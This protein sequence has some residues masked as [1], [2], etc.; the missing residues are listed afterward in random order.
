[1]EAIRGLD[2][3]WLGAFIGDLLIGGL[4]YVDHLGFR[5]IDRLF[6][7][8]QYARR[9]IGRALVLS[10]LDR[11]EVR[12]STGTRNDPACRLYQSLD[13]EAIG[14]REIAPEVTVTQF[15]RR[16]AAGRGPS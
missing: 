2:L 5:D 12:V 13:F 7:D 6:V 1:M 9:G 11:E 16:S 4:G 8:P 14:V 3:V 10:V 15:V